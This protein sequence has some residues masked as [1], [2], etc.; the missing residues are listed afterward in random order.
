MPQPLTLQDMLAYL[1]ICC[2]TEPSQRLRY[3]R[4][5][6]DMDE[7]YLAFSASKAEAA[8]KARGTS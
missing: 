6:Q 2:V 8:S 1:D 4:L 5:L 3:V 7:V